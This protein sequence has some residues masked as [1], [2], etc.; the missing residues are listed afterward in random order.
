MLM[1]RTSYLESETDFDGGSLQS[2]NSGTDVYWQAL[3]TTAYR[4]IWACMDVNGD[5]CDNG[6]ARI[7]TNTNTLPE[8]ERRKTICHELGH[9][10]GASHHGSGYG[11]MVSGTSTDE[12]YVTHTINHMNDLEVSES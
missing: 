4:G 10:T 2:C 3:N 8:D 5:E 9:S 12:T 11:C 1:V 7:S 6:E